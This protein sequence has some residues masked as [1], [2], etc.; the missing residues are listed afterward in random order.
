MDQPTPDLIH[1]Y[2]PW[3]AYGL[4]AIASVF[5]IIKQLAP[6]AFR[7]FVERMRFQAEQQAKKEAHALELEEERFGAALQEDMTLW[8]Q[9]VN[10]QTRVI[11]QNEAL[12]KFVT[13]H[14]DGRLN[15]IQKDIQE[16]DKRWLAVTKELAQGSGER[17]L[18]R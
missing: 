2:G 1:L 12:I 3:V 10:L 4:A 11:G 17:Q 5:V 7:A 9:M 13:E 14:L 18:M 16:I 8:A 6:D 15:G